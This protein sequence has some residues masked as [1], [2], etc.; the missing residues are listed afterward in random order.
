MAVPLAH[1]ACQ[2]RH[3][4]TPPP[5]QVKYFLPDPV[6]NDVKYQASAQVGWGGGRVAACSVQHVCMC[7]G[8]GGRG[9]AHHCGAPPTARA[10]AQPFLV[11]GLLTTGLAIG[12][13]NQ[14]IDAAASLAK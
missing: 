4:P 8:V 2:Q 3:K 13:H 11:F 10:P 12:H 5:L 6:A 1:R 14:L 9:L 7:L